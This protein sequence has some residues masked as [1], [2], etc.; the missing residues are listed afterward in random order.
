MREEKIKTV[1]EKIKMNI[2]EIYLTM[3]LWPS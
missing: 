3:S 2:S 1:R